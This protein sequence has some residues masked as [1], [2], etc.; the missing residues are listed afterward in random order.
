MAG[1]LGVRLGGL[2]HYQGRASFRAYMGEDL[3]P[4]EPVHIKQTVKLMYLTSVLA[5]SIGALIA[6]LAEYLPVKDVLI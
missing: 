4:L 2:N 6:I 1:A 5:V 3:N